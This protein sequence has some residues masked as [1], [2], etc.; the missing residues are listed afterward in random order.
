MKQGSNEF[1]YE[2][3]Y[4]EIIEAFPHVVWVGDAEGKVVFI[5][6]SWESWTGM[7][8][9]EA[10]GF[11]WASAIHSEDTKSLLEKWENAY[12]NGA[13]YEGE[14]RFVHKDGTILYC[15]FLAKPVFNE[16][17]EIINWVGLDMD[18]SPMKCVEKELTKKVT[19]LERINDLMI[20]RELKMME[21]KKEI[22]LLK[23]QLAIK[24]EV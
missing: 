4:K 8:A 10:L 11:G 17:G 3:I 2:Q 24:Q 16:Q 22:K 12:K 20:D 15:S 6:D 9:E 5:N 14:C 23:A 21:L 19:E 1:C 13:P 7:S 18:V